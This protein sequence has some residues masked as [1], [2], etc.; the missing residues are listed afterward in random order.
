M[1]FRHCV[2][3]IVC[4]AALLTNCRDR[5]ASK[6]QTSPD[7]SANTAPNTSASNDSES[8]ASK[9]IRDDASDGDPREQFQKA[10]EDTRTEPAKLS[11]LFLR[12]LEQ[13]EAV[14]TDFVLA[15][16]NISDYQAINAALRDHLKNAD[17][18]K[19]AMLMK[20]LD[21]KS[22]IGTSLL[23][24]VMESR[25]KD[26]PVK[27]YDWLCENATLSG[28]ANAAS[29]I[30]MAIGRTDDPSKILTRLEAT[31][32]PQ[33]VVASFVRGLVETWAAQSNNP[34]EAGKWLNTLS[35]QII[36]DEAVYSYVNNARSQNPKAAMNWAESIGDEGLR[37]SAILETAD[38][39]KKQDPAG[40][41]TWKEKMGSADLKSASE[42]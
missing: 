20:K 5:S 18:Q 11:A 7:A 32:P 23:G 6:A 36:V 29:V 27:A 26:D 3:T 13:D 34:E 17:T 42:Q 31:N 2:V 30:G 12:W 41:E 33:E 21:A 35:E 40:Y 1:F 24:D 22:D 38:A 8:T 15:N 14:A 10:L 37:R 39:W 28:T 19:L 25:A 16:N 9:T 4:A